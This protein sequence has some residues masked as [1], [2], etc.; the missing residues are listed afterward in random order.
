[1]ISVPYSQTGM[2]SYSHLETPVGL[3]HTDSLS[4][5]PPNVK[6]VVDDIESPWTYPA[7]FDFIFSRY[8][9]AAIQDWPKLVRNAYA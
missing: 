5:V 8:L 4:R 1:M 7:P 2:S 6:F 9:L 3:A